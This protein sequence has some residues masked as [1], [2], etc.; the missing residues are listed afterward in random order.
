MVDF[1]SFDL[2]HVP[3]QA[4]LSRDEFLARAR[5]QPEE[6]VTGDTLIRFMAR[7]VK[8]LLLKAKLSGRH[9]EH[10]IELDK[11]IEM[12]AATAEEAP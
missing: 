12:C 4:P 6:T 10:R 7:T 3:G 9:R 2:Y 5:Q 11:A 8:T 1:I